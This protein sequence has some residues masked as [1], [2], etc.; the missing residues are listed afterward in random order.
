M[1]TRRKWIG[2]LVV[3]LGAALAAACGGPFSSSGSPATLHGTVANAP[4]AGGVSASAEGRS[5]GVAVTVTVDQDPSLTATVNDDGTFT[6]TGLPA[7]G[8]TLIFRWGRHEARLSFTGVEAGQEITITV[9]LGD[10][11][12]V[13]LEDRRDGDQESTC[14]RGAGFWCQNQHGGN[15]NMSS[16]QFEQRAAQA[17]LL[18][19]AVSHLDTAA[20]IAEAVCNT[21]D[22][23]SRH[24]ATLAL[25][26]AAGLV[27][28]GTALE[29]ESFRGAPLATVADALAA[30]IQVASGALQVSRGERNE[31]K[32]V[33]ERINE[34][35]N[36]DSPCGADEDPE[37]DGDDD[38]EEAPAEGEMT[39]CHIPPGNPKAR[40]TITIG[41]S[42]W[43]AHRAHGD[44]QGACR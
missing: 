4:V 3:A 10:G 8:F 26:L 21:G 12:V 7:G 39:I 32:D 35:Q 2:G 27:E 18:L 15:P 17:A 41:A 37:D 34:N 16:A 28:S 13:L 36:T 31:I 43:P 5:A 42:A 44:Y 9:R 24:L 29:D 40:H 14:A 33:L 30:G 23:L 1:S 25:N 6:L 11:E 22:Q 20:E 38:D 19:S